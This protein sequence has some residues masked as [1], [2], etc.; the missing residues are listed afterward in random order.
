MQQSHTEAAAKAEASIPVLTNKLAGLTAQYQKAAADAKSAQDIAAAKALAEAQ[1]KAEA[2]AKAAEV[3]ATVTYDVGQTPVL[4]DGATLDEESSS[5]V[6][7]I[8]IGA[9]ALA[10]GASWGRNRMKKRQRA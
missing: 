8:A 6:P 9:I 1:A 10:V 5:V 2:D 4:A 3:T 7:L